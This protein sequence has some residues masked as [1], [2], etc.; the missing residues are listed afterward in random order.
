MAG[1]RMTF[2]LVLLVVVSVLLAASQ[3]VRPL[4]GLATPGSITG[5]LDFAVPDWGLEHGSF[6]PMC[7]RPGG[8]GCTLRLGAL[9]GGE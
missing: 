2:M 4:A 8:R 6:I 3:P 5:D 9:G 7:W 1:K